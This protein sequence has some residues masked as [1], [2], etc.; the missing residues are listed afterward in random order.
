[1]VFTAGT[2]EDVRITR[3][4]LRRMCDYEAG[5]QCVA[6]DLS[7]V[8]LYEGTSILTVKKGWDS[9]DATNTTFTASD[10]LNSSGIDITKGQQKTVTVKADIPSTATADNVVGLGIATTTDPGSTTTTDVTI[11]GLQSNTSPN[12]TVTKAATSLGGANWSSYGESDAYYLTLKSTG[13]LTMAASADTPIEAIQSVSVQ[14]VKIPNVAFLKVYL[15]ALL[16]SVDIKSITI[17]RTNLPNSRDSDFDTISL[18][19]GNGTLL[20]A[21][22][23]LATASTTFNL[24]PDDGDGVWE[25]GEY[26]NQPLIGAN[27]L[28]IKATL[29]GIRGY[30]GYG[31]ETGDEP[32]LCID[33]VTA[34]G[35]NSGTSP[36]GAGTLDICGNAQMFRMTKPTLALASPGTG[37]F[38]AGTKELIRFTVTA[39]ATSDV[40]WKKVIFDMSGS[41]TVGGVSF[42]VGCVSGNNTCGL[43]TDGIYMASGT[44]PVTTQLIA[45][46]SLQLWDA[47]T[48]TQ[49]SS[50]STGH[51]W[52]IDQATA[53]GTARIAFVAA[54]EQTVGAGQTKTYYV[55]GNVLYGGTAGDNLLTR[56]AARSTATTT[57]TYATVASGTGTFIWADGSGA[58]GLTAH[59]ASTADWTHDYKVPGIPTSSWTLSK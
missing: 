34:E 52:L 53:T 50:T 23:A 26:W 31:S 45:T 37:A 29:N 10:F 4:L 18:Y 44:D 22:Q 25:Q 6:N 42:T 15:K 32:K 1:L 14:G 24:V 43:K 8:A 49:V 46:T 36:Q 2:G 35:V 11:V 56:I 58:S 39:D 9:S 51:R 7:S 33:N 48:N 27:Y 38:G 3:I 57:G 21:P 59:S 28:I 54:T 20:A 41:V 5:S 16:E 30:Y 17:E 47:D 19:D 13:V 12:P 55:Q 40:K